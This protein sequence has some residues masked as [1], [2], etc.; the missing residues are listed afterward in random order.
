MR[1]GRAARQGGGGEEEEAEAEVA[2]EAAEVLERRREE[3]AEVSGGAC[4]RCGGARE[5]G[6][7]GG[8]RWS[9]CEALAGYARAVAEVSR[10]EHARYEADYVS[11][12]SE[13]EPTCVLRS[14]ESE[15]LK[16]RLSVS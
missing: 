3:E 9:Q 15:C 5:A 16:Y 14:L 11:D 1:G 10:P 4:R 2:Q 7:G 12:E 13:C 8:R 6:G